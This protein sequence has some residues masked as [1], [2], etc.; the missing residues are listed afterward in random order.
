MK[1]SEGF[2]EHFWEKNDFIVWACKIT[3]FGS[4]ST[5]NFTTKATKSLMTMNHELQCLS[6]PYK[7]WNQ[8]LNFLGW[9]WR[10]SEEMLFVC[11][12]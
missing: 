1:S 4:P 5:Q 7:A 12:A 8:N 10:E 6:E 3:C 2:H 11:I 9:I